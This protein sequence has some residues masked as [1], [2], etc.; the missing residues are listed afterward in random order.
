MRLH[1]PFLLASSGLLV[2]G[3]SLASGPLGQQKP[4]LGYQDTPML[5]GGKWHVHDG[6]RPQPRKI[7][8][9]TA[10]TPERPGKAPSDAVVLFDGTDTAQWRDSKG[11]P[12]KWVVDDGALVCVPNS[13]MIFSKPE[14]GDCQL[15]VEFA[16]PRDVKG[17][18]Q[19]RGNSGVFLIGRYEIQVLDSYDNPTY[20]DGQAAAIYGQFPPL[21]NA[22]RPPGEWQAYDILF[23][24]PRFHEDGTL[25]SPAYETILHNGVVVHNHAEV[26]GPMT[27]RTLTKYEPHG[28]RGPIALQ[29]HGNPVRFRNIWVRELKGYD[30]P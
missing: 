27:H 5:P 23:T 15:H 26:M 20:P 9:A 21:V 13:G 14:F 28:P 18:G 11:N 7:D 8:P 2:A 25:K 16:T 30:E 12:T 10:S 3:L 6:E 17:N 29:D 4:P 24:A 22:S 1:T 19:G